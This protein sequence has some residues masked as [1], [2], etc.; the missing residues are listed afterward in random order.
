MQREIS[1]PCLKTKAQYFPQHIVAA[2]DML[3]TCGIGRVDIGIRIEKPVQERKEFTRLFIFVFTCPRRTRLPGRR[4]RRRR[5]KLKECRKN[6]QRD[7]NK[8]Q[9]VQKREREREVKKRRRKRRRERRGASQR[10]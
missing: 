1:H 7:K 6:K 8:L 10:R 4:R 9:G 5:R 2:D 3:A